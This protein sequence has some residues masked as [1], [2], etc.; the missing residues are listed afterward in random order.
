MAEGILRHYGSD[1]FEVFSAGTKPSNVNETAIQVMHEIGIDISRQRSKHVNEFFGKHFD[2]IVT[3][4][5][6]ANAAW[7]SGGRPLGSAAPRGRRGEACPNFPGNVTRLHWSFPDPPHD[8]KITENV[9]NE[10]RKVRDLIHAKFSRF[11]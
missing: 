10:F 2:Y 7:P 5:D 9:V 3:V 6:S 11:S 8:K 4:C 1:T